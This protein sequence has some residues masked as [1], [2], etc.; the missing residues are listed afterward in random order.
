MIRYVLD[1]SALMTFFRAE[2]GA[3]IVLA[4]LEEDRPGTMVHEPGDREPRVHL[5]FMALMEFQYHALR[6]YGPS[7][8]DRAMRALNA[9]PVQVDESAPAWREEAAR[10]KAAGGLSIADAWIAA[11]ALLLNAELVHKDPEYER[12]EGLRQVRLPY[13]AGA[14]TSNPPDDRRTR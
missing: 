1:T 6:V 5:P 12:V 3:E 13:K 11:L 9:W 14:S 2:P 8:T 10:V 4:I 7:G